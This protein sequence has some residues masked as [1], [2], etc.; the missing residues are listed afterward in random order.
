M[1]HS[2]KGMDINNLEFQYAHDILQY[3]NESVF[4][5]GKAGTGKSTFL[6][7]ISNNTNKKHIVLAPTGIAAIN[8]KGETLHS[9]FQLPFGPLLPNDERLNN[10][11]FSKQKV[12]LVKELDLLIIDEISMVRADII[13]A[14]D[15]VLRKITK[16]KNQPFGGKQLL[17]V[18]D[19]F[20][21]EPVVKN[22]E[23]PILENFYDTPYFFGARVFR[24]LNLVNIELE[25]VYRQKDQAFIEVLNKVRNGISEPQLL[26]QLNKKADPTFRQKDQD[27]YITLTATR[28][29]ADKTNQKHLKALNGEL[30]TYEGFIEGEFPSK[31]LPTDYYLK[32]KEG[33][34]VMF[35]KNDYE[36]TDSEGETVARRWVNGTIGIVD[37]FEEGGI[38]VK[39]E[40]GE[41]YKVKQEKWESIT[42][43]YD[44]SANKVIEE[45]KGS[46][47]QYPLKLAWAVTI[48]KSQGMTFDQV[49]IDLGRGAFAAGQLYVALSRCTNLDGI[50]LKSEITPRD[51]IVRKEVIDFYKKMNDQQQIQ[52]LLRPKN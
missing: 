10:P 19:L 23:W 52:E 32:L 5:T 24:E 14:I 41:V 50:V 1:K 34:Q 12:K 45:V 9:F 39:L 49:I 29:V 17:F 42:Y 44:E 43:Q 6:K 46:F 4:L 28:S 25:K 51:L 47:W 40:N 30:K 8:V 2:Q 22:E 20:Q 37:S 48:H 15:K 11:R 21:L 33:A 13:D 7:L 36:G 31:N 27:F 16:R 26:N 18:G 35:V 3:T 38:N